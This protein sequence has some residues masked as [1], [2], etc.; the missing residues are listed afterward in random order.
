MRFSTVP[1]Y[2]ERFLAISSLD[3]QN[4]AIF[5]IHLFRDNIPSNYLL[6]NT[7]ASFFC[8]AWF[9]QKKF[10]PN[11]V[12]QFVHFTFPLQQFLNILIPSS[13]VSNPKLGFAI[14]VVYSG[15][16]RLLISFPALRNLDANIGYCLKRALVLDNESVN[17][18]KRL[19]VAAVRL[20]KSLSK[21]TSFA[22][23]FRL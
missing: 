13:F 19:V 5:S 3:L 14:D 2:F 1:G 20:V 4:D 6:L 8:I 7:I 16:N 11:P 15:E 9:T 18:L 10:W 21:I 12:H 22:V 17:M 23:L